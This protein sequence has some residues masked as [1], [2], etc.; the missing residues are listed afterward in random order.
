VEHPEYK[1]LWD[2]TAGE[3]KLPLEIGQ[4][5]LSTITYPLVENHDLSM[6]NA[7]YLPVNM[8]IYGPSACR[9]VDQEDLS[10]Y[11][12]VQDSIRVLNKT[13]TM[14]GDLHMSIGSDAL[15]LL[16]CTDLSEGKGF[17]LHS[18]TSRISCS[19]RLSPL[20]GRKRPL[21]YT[22]PMAFWF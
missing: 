4:G 5:S 21:R 20:P 7:L 12:D 6:H 19:L 18:E 2:G 10:G 11:V 14:S 22:R 13:E 1:R 15:R 8:S 3:L 16:G 9:G 17:T